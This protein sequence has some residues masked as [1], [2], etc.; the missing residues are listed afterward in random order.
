MQFCINCRHHVSVE[1]FTPCDGTLYNT[2]DPCRAKR[3]E[4]YDENQPIIL[5]K[6]KEYN[7]N[8]KE[9]LQK[10]RKIQYAKNAEIVK[11]N[12]RAYNNTLRGKAVHTLY[13]ALERGIPTE[14][15]VNDV[16]ALIESP[17]FYCGRPSVNDR[18]NG[19]DRLCS[20]GI[21]SADNCVS[22]CWP[23]NNAKGA[24]DPQTFVL[25]M[26]MLDALRSGRATENTAAHLWGTT[27]SMPYSGYACT[28][29]FGQR[30]GISRNVFDEITARPCVYCARPSM[31]HGSG[32]HG[33]DRI[34]NAVGYVV[35]NVH[36]CCRECNFMRGKFTVDQFRET[37][38][39]V[40]ARA[41]AILANVPDTIDQCLEIRKNRRKKT[42]A[43]PAP[44]CT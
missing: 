36:P 43:G 34:D 16:I 41:D 30:I 5:E 1:S 33:L 21:Y 2:C 9:V 28:M 29:K 11:K 10:R 25:R 7:K 3:K 12:Q 20:A 15:E 24:L 8:N 27:R 13:Q 26:A 31:C 44:T 14:L 6:A 35:E 23:C 39:L 40:A 4:W 19:L 18:V 42:D 17:C 32:R 38:E 22:C 37:V